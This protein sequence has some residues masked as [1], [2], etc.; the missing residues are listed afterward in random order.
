MPSPR[1]DRLLPLRAP[2]ASPETG[3]PR[4]P[5]G[6]GTGL[7]PATGCPRAVLV[8]LQLSPLP[9]LRDLPCPRPGG[10]VSVGVLPG[11]V[12]GEVGSPRQCW[13]PLGF[14]GLKNEGGSTGQGQA[15]PGRVSGSAGNPQ[16]S[17]AAFSSPEN[18]P[19]GGCPR[20]VSRQRG[21]CLVPR[22]VSPLPALRLGE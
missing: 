6:L 9:L 17:A 8:P 18:S 12:G 14:R 10:L 21:H 22:R 3:V 2:R 11:G 16:F 19:S 13:D 1:Q 5:P 20:A 4:P 15:L 7:P